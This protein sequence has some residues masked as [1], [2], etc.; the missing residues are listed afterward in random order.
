M[1]LKFKHYFIDPKSTK[2]IKKW[3]KHLYTLII[4]STL[5]ILLSLIT[6]LLTESIPV[7][8]LVPALL[9]PFLLVIYK[10]D[11]WAMKC[12]FMP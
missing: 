9:Y 4:H 1:F 2:T 7:S 6:K 5:F 10:I 3:T 12:K 11:K 8:L